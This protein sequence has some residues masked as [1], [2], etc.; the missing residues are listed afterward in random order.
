LDGSIEIKVLRLAGK[1]SNNA[2][3]A[4]G[5]NDKFGNLQHAANEHPMPSCEAPSRRYRFYQNTK[6]ELSIDLK[7]AKSLGPAV[8]STLLAR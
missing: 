8:P 3:G 4:A 7:N 5:G 1:S 6:F 2:G